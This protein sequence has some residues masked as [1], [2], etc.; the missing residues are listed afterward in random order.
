MAARAAEIRAGLVRTL[1]GVSGIGPVLGHP[2]RAIPANLTLYLERD[3]FEVV[4]QGQVRAIRWFFIGTLVVY[5]QDPEQGEADIDL[6]TE[7]ILTAIRDDPWLDGTLTAGLATISRGDDDWIE[8][9]TNRV[10][11][12]V[13]DFRIEVLDK[14]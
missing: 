7:A 6:L 12:R 3:G 4:S 1:A 14:H 10:L 9:P 2:P 13:T 8:L 11:Y 5:W